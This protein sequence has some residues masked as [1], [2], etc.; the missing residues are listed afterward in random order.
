MHTSIMNDKYIFLNLNKN[1]I[2]EQHD[3]KNI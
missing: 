2:N 1:A 3:K